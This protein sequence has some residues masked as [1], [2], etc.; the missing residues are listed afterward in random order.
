MPIIPEGVI[1]DS[2][3]K[4]ELVSVQASGITSGQEAAR[5]LMRSVEELREDFVSNIVATIPQDKLKD[6]E[7]Q[8][9]LALSQIFSPIVSFLT[10]SDLS[11]ARIARVLKLI[12]IATTDPITDLFDFQVNKKPDVQPVNINNFSDI[13]F[14]SDLNVKNFSELQENFKS[15]EQTIKDNLNIEV[16]PPEIRV[17]APK[18]EVTPEAPIVNVEAPDLNALL[19]ALKPLGLISR[20]ASGAISVRLSDGKRFLKNLVEIKKSNDRMMQAFSQ[21]P[22]MTRKDFSAASKALSQKAT[23]TSNTKVTVGSTTTSVVSA[24]ADRI[25]LTLVNDSNETIYISKSGTAVMNEGIRLNANGGSV[26]ITDYTGAVAAICSSGSK[27]LTVCE[28]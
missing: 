24:N 18:V 6:S 15:L 28:V 23:A 17:K 20:K 2:L 25:S 1:N 8:I 9:T 7:E 3:G 21:S 19:D 16:K 13:H 27:N 10:K 22:G 11:P 5:F 14:S 4:S 12:E 26:L